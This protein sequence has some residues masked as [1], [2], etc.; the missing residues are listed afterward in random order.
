MIEQEIIQS[1]IKKDAK[2]QKYLYQKYSSVLLGICIRY[3]RSLKDAEDI[4]QDGFL[5][6]FINIKNYSGKGS[7]EGWMKRII[8]NTSITYYNNNLKFKYHSDITE[9]NETDISNQNFETSEFSQEELLNVINELS[10][11]YRM[12]FNM[13]AIE[14][15][16]HKEIAKMLG[17]DINTSKSQ[18]SRARKIVQQKL[19]ELKKIKY[20]RK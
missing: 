13:F 8:I 7:F 3:S 6:I 1:C 15:Y 4:L 14:G 10:D 2:A 16:K 9:I 18:F 19:L 5:K 17:I 11:G 12:V 20:V